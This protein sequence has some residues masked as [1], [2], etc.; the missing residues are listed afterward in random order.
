MPEASESLPVNQVIMPINISL[1]RD[2]IEQGTL[3]RLGSLSGY[4]TETRG[5]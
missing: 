5:A 1:H 4:R 2:P 3:W